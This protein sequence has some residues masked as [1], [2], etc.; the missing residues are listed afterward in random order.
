MA[1]NKVLVF[2][3]LSSCIVKHSKRVALHGGLLVKASMGFQLRSSRFEPHSRQ[4]LGFFSP[5]LCLSFHAALD[6]IKE[7]SCMCWEIERGLTLCTI[8]IICPWP[9]CTNKSHVSNNYSQV[10]CQ[11]QSCTLLIHMFKKYLSSRCRHGNIN[12]PWSNT[13]VYITRKL[14]SIRTILY[15]MRTSGV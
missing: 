11:Q 10:T 5:R 2:K 1:S 6:Y 7:C 3:K 9:A 13:Y 15:C 8:A 12:A 14:Y 4:M